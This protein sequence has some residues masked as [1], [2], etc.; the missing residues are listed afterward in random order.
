MR[1]VQAASERKG[2]APVQTGSSPFAFVVVS[3][4]DLPGDMITK[5]RLVKHLDGSR[6]VIEKGAAQLHTQPLGHDLTSSAES[7]HPL[8]S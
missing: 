7:G 8:Q 3:R 4:C 2:T 6:I 5:K 1:Q